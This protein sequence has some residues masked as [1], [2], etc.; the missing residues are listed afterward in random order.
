MDATG[1]R[2]QADSI[3]HRLSK[4]SYIQRQLTGCI[5]I[6][7]MKKDAVRSKEFM[8]AI[9]KRL[10]TRRIFWNLETFIGGRIQEGDYWIKLWWKWRYLVPVESIHSP[11]LT[12][13]V[14][15]QRHHDNRK[16]YNTASATL[17]SNVMIKKSVSMQVRRSQRHMKAILLNKDDQEIYNG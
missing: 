7:R 16:T 4:G 11:M 9:Q 12:L 15:N 1:Q 2:F 14:F 13:N 3:C 17:I 6:L 8:F 10:K 5:L